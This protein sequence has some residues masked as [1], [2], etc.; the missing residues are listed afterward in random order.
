[1]SFRVLAVGTIVSA[2]LLPNTIFLEK[3]RKFRA[4][5]ENTF[6]ENE[7][8]VSNKVLQR[9]QDV[10]DDLE[11]PQE[12]RKGI[13][14][15]NVHDIHMFSAGTTISTYGA[16]IGIPPNYEYENIQHLTADQ[17]EIENKSVP[18]TEETSQKFLESLVLS[19]N[20]QKFAMAREVLRVQRFD[21]WIKIINLVFDCLVVLILQDITYL[22]M[23]LATKTLIHRFTVYTMCVMLGAFMYIKTENL[24]DESTDQEI[25]EQLVKLGPKYIQ[26]GKEF[27]EKLCEENTITNHNFKNKS[28]FITQW[29]QKQAL[30][31]VS[32]QKEFFDLKLQELESSSMM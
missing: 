19:E 5:Y 10:M 1:M 20:A 15:F 30:F 9:F 7:L 27:Y 3:Y 4:R 28:N 18:W 26:G 14:I 29:W 2:K 21:F 11:V 8:P 13:K 16:I 31:L 25:T 22:A 17:I 32:Q 23:K 24:L 12:T 6:D